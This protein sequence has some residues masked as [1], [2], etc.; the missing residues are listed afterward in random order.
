MEKKLEITAIQSV[1]DYIMDVLFRERPFGVL[2]SEIC[3]RDREVQDFDA[4]MPPTADVLGTLLLGDQ[5][6]KLSIIRV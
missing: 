3:R 4:C 1:G 6:V 5:P 2:T